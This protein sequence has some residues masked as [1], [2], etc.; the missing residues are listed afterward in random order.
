MPLGVSS[1]PHGAD[2]S[3]ESKLTFASAP[4][5]PVQGRNV[6]D[7]AHIP[8]EERVVREVQSGVYVCQEDGSR[9]RQ[10]ER[11]GRQDV[12]RRDGDPPR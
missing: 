6:M 10:R 1:G 4:G 12:A 5:R 2:R 3:N 9:D 7:E 8:G 11:E